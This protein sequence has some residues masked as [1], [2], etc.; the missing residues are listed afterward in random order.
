MRFTQRPVKVQAHQ[1]SREEAATEWIVEEMLAGRMEPERRTVE[2]EER[3]CGYSVRTPE[4]KMRARLG[5]YIVMEPSGALR[6]VKASHFQQLY[7]KEAK[8]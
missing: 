7:S 1:I 8:A 3:F 4:G 2:G 6:V 5:D